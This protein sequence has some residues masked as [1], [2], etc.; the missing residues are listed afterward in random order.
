MWLGMAICLKSLVKNDNIA[1]KGTVRYL[2]P[3]L[4]EPPRH[5]QVISHLP[6]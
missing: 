4:L 6:C 5:S 2:A 3:E 1:T